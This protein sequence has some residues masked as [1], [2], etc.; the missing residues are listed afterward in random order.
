VTQATHITPE[1]AIDRLVTY[2]ELLPV[3]RRGEYLRAVYAVNE[4]LMLLREIQ[5]LIAHMQPTDQL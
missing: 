4:Q 2:A 5:I 3:E 1:H